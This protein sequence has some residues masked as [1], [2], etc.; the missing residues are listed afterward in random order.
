MFFV[1][2]KGGPTLLLLLFVIIHRNFRYGRLALGMGFG[3]YLL[4]AV[5]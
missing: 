1:F 2:A 3:F 5:S 4:L